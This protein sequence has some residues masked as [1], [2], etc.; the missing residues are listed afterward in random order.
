MIRDEDP[1]WS[2]ADVL[3]LLFRILL[4]VVRI[5]FSSSPLTISP[6]DS[7][8]G[9]RG[10]ILPARVEYKTRPCSDGF[11]EFVSLSVTLDMCVLWFAKAE[12]VWMDPHRFDSFAVLPVGLQYGLAQQRWQSAGSD[13][14]KVQVQILL[15]GSHKVA[16]MMKRP[17]SKSEIAGR[18]GTMYAEGLA[19]N[20]K[21]LRFFRLHQTPSHT[22]S[23]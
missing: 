7:D 14:I 15:D 2:L 23:T 18:S 4:V 1:E 9:E 19:F 11:H 10:L 3:T 6:S 12:P 8:D 17:S 21:L 13:E 20:F 5:A 16:V 22:S